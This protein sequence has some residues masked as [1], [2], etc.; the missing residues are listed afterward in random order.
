[1]CIFPNTLYIS[2]LLLD[3]YF[4]RISFFIRLVREIVHLAIVVYMSISLLHMSSGMIFFCCFFSKSFNLC[5]APV[6]LELKP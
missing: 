1:M 5:I 3:A 6:S 4:L 2:L